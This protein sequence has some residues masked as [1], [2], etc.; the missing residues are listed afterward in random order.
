MK[1]PT[2]NF[3]ILTAWGLLLSLVL[4]AALAV[5]WELMAWQDF[6]YR[7]LHDLI[8]IAA[9]V[10]HYGPLNAL[11]PDFHLTSLDE[12]VR[13]FA[14]LVEA[15]HHQGAGLQS[16][17]YFGIDGQKIGLLLTQAEII[18]LNDVARLVSRLRPLGWAAMVLAL[19]GSVWIRVG[20]EILSGRKLLAVAAG[21]I[22]LM[23]A[24]LLMFGAETL[25]YWLHT[26]VFPPGHQ[27]FFYYEESLMSMMMQ[28]P[29]LF[30]A[31]ALIWAVLVFM[32]IT[33]WYQ[34]LRRS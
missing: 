9:T 8:G 21:G 16:V 14:V 20:G 11:R 13:L 18:H 27:W 1:Q 5:G 12:R 23:V 7:W 26:V 25:F 6:G 19:V 2:V 34:L 24:L 22:G 28:A 10:D 32:A 30:G 17:A 4:I 29:D 33:I 31:I 15:I 3:F